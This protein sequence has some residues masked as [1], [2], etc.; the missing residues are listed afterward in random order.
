[1]LNIYY[2]YAYASVWYPAAS[3]ILYDLLVNI[4]GY[5]TN[6]QDIAG[7]Q[8]AYSAAPEL[9]QYHISAIV[10]DWAIDVSRPTY[11]LLINL[12]DPIC[13]C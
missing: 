4:S 3:S 1:M 7:L 9:V 11:A 2:I 10:D 8:K 12:F 5:Q 13:C 6:Q